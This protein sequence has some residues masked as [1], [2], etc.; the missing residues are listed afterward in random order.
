MTRLLPFLPH[1]LATW[2]PFL[3]MLFFVIAPLIPGV[4]WY[5][6]GTS[7]PFEKQWLVRLMM[8]LLG[9]ALLVGWYSQPPK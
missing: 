3:G 7:E 4:T 5:R 9:L 1:R 6:K 8:F 2:I